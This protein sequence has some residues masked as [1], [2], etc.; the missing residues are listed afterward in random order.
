LRSET[1]WPETIAAGWNRLGGDST[2]EIV[3][4]AR[5]AAG[6][7]PSRPELYGDGRAAEHIEEVLRDWRAAGG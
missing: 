4:A 6:D 1:E 2:E 7:R 3:A 5:A